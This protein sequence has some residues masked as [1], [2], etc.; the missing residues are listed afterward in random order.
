MTPLI[1]VGLGYL[2]MGQAINTMSSGELQRLKLGH[3]LSKQNKKSIL[4]F[5]EPSKGLHFHDINILMKALDKLV[6]NGNT[7]IIIEHNLDI[8]KNVD[9]VID[10]GPDAGNNGGKIIFNGTPQDLMKE[11][12]HTGKALKI[13]VIH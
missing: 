2:K 5:D 9:W 11:T 3:F 12:S 8:I 6:D 4:I 13:D 1:D 7:V 10:M